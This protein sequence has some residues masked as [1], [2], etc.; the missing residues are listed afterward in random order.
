ML[1]L[2]NNTALTSV[3]CVFQ[4]A[5][6]QT[7][8]SSGNSEYK[9]KFDFSKLIP[10]E[11]ISQIVADSVHGYTSEGVTVETQYSGGVA[12]FKKIPAEIEYE[13]ST[14]FEDT[15]LLVKF[16][17]T[18]GG[19]SGGGESSVTL[20]DPAITTT[21]LS[22]G[23]VGLSYSAAISATG[24]TP[25]TWSITSGTLPGGLTLN[26]STGVI[27]GIPTVKGTSNFTVQAKNTSGTAT[28]E[29]TIVVG[30]IYSGVGNNNNNGSVDDNNNNGSADDNGNSI[31]IPSSDG[32]SDDT[33][34]SSDLGCNAG[35]AGIILLACAAL[36]VKKK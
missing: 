3:T 18:T 8:N 11:N 16:S 36:I 12:M 4:N 24:T 31:T 21:S 19:S 33:L 20:K 30:D 15:T 22:Y 13:I 35:Y 26:S 10:A 2:S 23:I 25:I 6:S 9:Y 7:I 27:S 5:A 34:Q 14:S 28:Q 29:L 32:G 17:V 1:D